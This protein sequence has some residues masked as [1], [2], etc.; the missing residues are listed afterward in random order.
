MRS[1]DRTVAVLPPPLSGY[2]QVENYPGDIARLLLPKLDEFDSIWELTNS[3]C[4]R[5]LE[6]VAA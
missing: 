4:D 3:V 5:Y 2:N 1:E 6:P